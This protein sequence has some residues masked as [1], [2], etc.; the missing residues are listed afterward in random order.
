MLLWHACAGVWVRLSGSKHKVG[1]RGEGLLYMLS[2][3]SINTHIRTP[4]R[5]HTYIYTYTH[6]HTH[7]HTYSH[8]HIHTHTHTHTYTHTHTH[9]HTHTGECTF[10]M[11][12]VFTSNHVTCGHRSTTRSSLDT[13]NS[14]RTMGEGGRGGG[15]EGGKDKEG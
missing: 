9:T 2:V 1:E 12:T 5:M 3:Y 14:A 7:A 11:W 13:F 15:K 6:M 8:M 4:L 10:P